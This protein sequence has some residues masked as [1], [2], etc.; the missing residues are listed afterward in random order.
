MYPP[1]RQLDAKATEKM[2]KIMKIDP[3]SYKMNATPQWMT[4][5]NSLKENDLIVLSKNEISDPSNLFNLEKESLANIEKKF[6][7][8]KGVIL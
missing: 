6:N 8:D 4:T 2:R 1:R 7:P 5:I 3:D